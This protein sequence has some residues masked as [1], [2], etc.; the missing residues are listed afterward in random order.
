MVKGM[1][2]KEKGLYEKLVGR[3]NQAEWASDINKD[4]N[5]T[6][7]GLP[8]FNSEQF[9]F[10]GQNALLNILI[11]YSEYDKKVGYCQSMN[12]LAAFILLVNGGKE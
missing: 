5:R 7:P 8:F 9:G 2:K 6:F 10:N 4:I 11:A 3:G 12:F 1:V